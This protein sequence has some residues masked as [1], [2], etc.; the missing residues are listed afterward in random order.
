MQTID[1]LRHGDTGQR[2][3]RGQ[4]D[5]A[6]SPAGWEQMH[7]AVAGGQWDVV[8][9]S[10]LQRCAA[11]ARELADQRAVPLHLDGRLAEYHFGDWQAVPLEQIAQRDADALEKFWSD[12]V[13]CP[14]PGAES[15]ATFEAR[16]RDVLDA[17]ARLPQQRVL[18]VTHGGVIRLLHC[19]S[20]GR[21]LR[22]MS[23]VD[24]PHASLHRFQPMHSIATVLGVSA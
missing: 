11:F 4:L 18:V 8:V 2:G 22:C 1:F 10:P 14:P 9:S 13:A 16:V 3:F 12:P 6:L 19:L 23:E 5:D 17:I 24:V 7:T 20:Q 15:V 21:E